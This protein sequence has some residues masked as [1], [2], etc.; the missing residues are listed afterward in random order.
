MKSGG[1][2]DDL[3]EGFSELETAASE[4]VQESN[5]EDENDDELISEPEPSGDND[6]NDD[7]AQ[8]DL[9]SLDTES[10]SAEKMSR[11]NRMFSELFKTIIAAPGLSISSALDKFAEDGKDLSRAEISAAMLNLRNRRMYGR[12][13][14]VIDI[15]LV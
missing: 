6:D 7:P 15:L 10:D 8:S 9:E 2:E 11:K 14:Q 12:A 5:I 3:E 13:L 4:A 1:Y